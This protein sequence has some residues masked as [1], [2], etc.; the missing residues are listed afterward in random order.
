[1]RVRQHLWWNMANAGDLLSIF[2]LRKQ[3]ML[4]RIDAKNSVREV[5]PKEQL[6][7][8]K[9]GT[10]DGSKALVE[11]GPRRVPGQGICTAA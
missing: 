10:T 4:A 2:N 8:L 11:A 6:D 9:Q 5:L 7:E 3:M 1:M